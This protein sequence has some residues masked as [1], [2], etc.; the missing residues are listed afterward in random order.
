MRR[1]EAH[2][3]FAFCT[4]VFA[5]L[6]FH[7]AVLLHRAREVNAI[8]DGTLSPAQSSTPQAA[9]KQ[10]MSLEQQGDY[11]EA[12]TAYKQV[13]Q[14]QDPALRHAALFNLGNLHLREA[15]A[16]GPK[17]GTRWLPLIEFAK[18]SYRA[19][20]REDASHW[21]ARYNLEHALRLAPELDEL[22]LTDEGPPPEREPA[23]STAPNAR[24][25]LP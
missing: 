13:L 24:I 5:A 8:L 12:V 6:A 25:D 14:S 2:W 4:L 16:H 3:V 9:F 7:Q 1:R 11:D 19:V 20:L 17:D 22:S 23:R 15:L 21:D 10:A 18:Q